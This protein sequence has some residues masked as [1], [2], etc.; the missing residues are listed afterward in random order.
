MLVHA[1]KY[2]NCSIHNFKWTLISIRM[3][4]FISSWDDSPWDDVENYIVNKHWHEWQFA[5][6]HSMLEQKNKFFTDHFIV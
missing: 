3:K 2:N 1:E 6:D 4:W 5:V